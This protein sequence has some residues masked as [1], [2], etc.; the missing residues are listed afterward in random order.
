M[1]QKEELGQL[2]TQKAELGHCLFLLFVSLHVENRLTSPT[3]YLP[4]FCNVSHSDKTTSTV[5]EK[6]LHKQDPMDDRVKGPN[7]F[8]RENTKLKSID[9][10]TSMFVIFVRQHK[11]PK[12]GLL[13]DDGRPEGR[14]PERIRAGCAIRFVWTFPFMYGCWHSKSKRL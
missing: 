3:Q 11:I 14:Q 6:F 9:R 8:S 12:R 13:H 1:T 4:L 10:R 5:T 2:G 7:S